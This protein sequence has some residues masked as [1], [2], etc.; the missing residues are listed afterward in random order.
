[1]WAVLLTSWQVWEISSVL[2]NP[3]PADT[4]Y[5]FFPPFLFFLIHPIKKHVTRTSYGHSSGPACAHAPRAREP[6]QELPAGTNWE[7][8]KGCTTA[9]ASQGKGVQHHHGGT[10][11]SPIPHALPANEAVEHPGSAPCLASDFQCELMQVLGFLCASK[12][13]IISLPLRSTVGISTL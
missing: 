2:N 13:Q 3:P 6:G 12:T 4:S 9:T 7:E 5:M 11:A 8:G 1:M 10:T